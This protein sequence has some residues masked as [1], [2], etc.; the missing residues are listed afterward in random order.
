MFTRLQCY[1]FFPPHLFELQTN[2]LPTRKTCI[3]SWLVPQ[4]LTLI[5]LP[6]HTFKASTK[7]YTFKSGLPVT[8]H[9]RSVHPLLWRVRLIYSLFNFF[10]NTIS[11]FKLTFALSVLWRIVTYVLVFETERCPKCEHDRAYFM[12]IQ[13]RSADEPMTTFYK[14]CKCGHRWR[15]WHN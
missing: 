6:R 5:L 7:S 1:R 4:Y 10:P 13:T 9:E 11:S 3:K 14:C 12:Q 2:P 8:I 15:E